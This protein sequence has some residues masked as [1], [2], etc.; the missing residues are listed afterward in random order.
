MT[1][2]EYHPVNVLK[3]MIPAKRLSFMQSHKGLYIDIR[4]HAFDVGVCVMIDVML[5]LPVIGIAT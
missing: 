2:V 5:D 1:P 3:T 4:I